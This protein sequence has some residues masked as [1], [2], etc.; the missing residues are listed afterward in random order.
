M[1]RDRRLRS[2]AGRFVRAEN[3]KHRGVR[4]AFGLYVFMI[5]AG[6]LIAVGIAIDGG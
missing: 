1:P 3:G 4:A 5:G 2:G 6:L